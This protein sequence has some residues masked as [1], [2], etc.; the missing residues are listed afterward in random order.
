MKVSGADTKESPNQK[1]EYKLNPDYVPTPQQKEYLTHEALADYANKSHSDYAKPELAEK[2]NPMY[3]PN[4]A[5]DLWKPSNDWEKEN[6]PTV[7]EVNDQLNK[8]N[9]EPVKP[10]EII[11]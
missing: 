6:S 9:P 11:P 4:I 10:P 3:S 7:K 1:L 8:T 5:S 2:L